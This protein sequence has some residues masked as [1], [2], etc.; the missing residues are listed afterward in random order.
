M[1][2]TKRQGVV[3]LQ[4]AYTP[5]LLRVRQQMLEADGYTVISA[6][7]NDQGTAL[8]TSHDFDVA[9]VGFSRSHSTRHEMVRWLK[10]HV[11]RTPVLALLAHES[12]HFPDADGETLSED[13][14]V[15]LA[16]VRQAVSQ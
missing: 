4:V 3:L 6:L 16:A 14:Q 5:E 12:E 11:P 2:R 8:A 1:G 7:G 9:I 15:W 13:P 10:L